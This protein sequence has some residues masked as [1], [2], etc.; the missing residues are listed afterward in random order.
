[1]GAAVTGMALLGWVGSALVVASLLQS[2][3]VRLRSIN[4]AACVALTIFNAA[5]GLPSMVAMNTVLALVN[6]WHLAKLRATATPEPGVDSVF[7]PHR[8][9]ADQLDI[10]EQG[11]D[12][13][14][15]GRRPVPHDDRHPIA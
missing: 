7:E 3:P 12:E 14:D 4:L 1:M 6:G 5:A 10:A 8:G 15:V 9:R 2:E 11:S 13:R